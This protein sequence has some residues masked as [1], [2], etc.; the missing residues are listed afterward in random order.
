LRR[1]HLITAILWSAPAE[2]SGDG[3]LAY[4]AR[5]L[6]KAVS[7]FACHRT[8]HVRT[9]MVSG[10]CVKMQPPTEHLITAILWSAP[11]ERSGDGALA[12]LA[13]SPILKRCRASLATAL[14]MSG[15]QWFP[16]AV[17]RCSRRREHLTTAILWSAPAERSG[18]GALAYPARSPILK[19]CRASLATALHMS[20]QQR[21]R[22]LCQDALPCGA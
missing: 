6:A 12:Y 14:H 2:R 8:P 1:E 16:V 11:A 9:T 7:R 13:R 17:S 22:W 4:L 19:R 3:A 20:G 5:S 15:Q 21:F 10:G 18:D